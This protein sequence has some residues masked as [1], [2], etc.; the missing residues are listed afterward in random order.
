[1]KLGLYFTLGDLGLENS[2]ALLEGV[3][4]GGVD[5]LEIGLPF[6]DPLLD[7][8]IIQQSHVRAV[9]Q[10]ISW[11]LLCSAIEKLKAHCSPKQQISIMTSAQHLYDKS[12]LKQLPNVDGIL[13]TDIKHNLLSP[14][15]LPSKRVWFLNQEIV[16]DKSFT[17]C[18]DD[19]SMVYLARV[20]GITG[21]NQS[22]ESTTAKAIKIIRQVTNK[23]IWLG[24]G[25]SSYQDVIMAK[26]HGADGAI[27][28][29]AFVKKVTEYYL[30]KLQSKNEN[31]QKKL[32]KE[33]GKNYYS[34][35]KKIMGRTSSFNFSQC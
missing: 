33:F 21:A 23:E 24:F 25:I 34:D 9:A 22:E 27:I 16:L 4:D 8:I 13:V 14:F 29:S 15:L 2:L 3:L 11:K 28:G 17:A 12:R 6:S 1:M 19:I 10:T 7:G 31:E 5:L 30:T 35:I 32:L 18:P 20:Q 26:R